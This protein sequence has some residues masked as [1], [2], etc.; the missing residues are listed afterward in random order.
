MGIWQHTSYIEHDDPRRV[1]DAIVSL[2]RRE[3]IQQIA[4]PEPFSAQQPDAL[5]FASAM[6]NAAWAVGVLPGAAG[7][8]IIKT[9]PLEL[10]GERAPNAIRMRLVDLAALL[11]TA[12]LQINL[13][14]TD[15]LVLI[16]VD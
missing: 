14:E 13:Y 5:Q 3:G 1:A 10:L 6:S 4:E 11:G 16:E 8:T 9:R 12:A 15:F 2:L 7:W